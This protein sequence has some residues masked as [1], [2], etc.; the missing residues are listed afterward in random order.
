MAT[1]AVHYSSER[2]KAFMIN[3]RIAMNRHALKGGEVSGDVPE[4]NITAIIQK[5]ELSSGRNSPGHRG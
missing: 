3:V 5:S 1:I 4:G 2:L